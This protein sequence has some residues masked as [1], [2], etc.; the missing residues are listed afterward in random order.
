MGSYK[1]QDPVGSCGI[2]YQGGYS[3]A[4]E[5]NDTVAMDFKPHLHLIDLATR[6][7]N[8]VVIHSKRKGLL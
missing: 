3:L 5:F 1:I 4:K 8:A 7:G 2:F 6:H